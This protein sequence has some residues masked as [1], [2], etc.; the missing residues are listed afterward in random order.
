MSVDLERRRVELIELQK[1]LRATAAG[2]EHELS[3]DDESGELPSWGSDELADHASVTHDREVDDT[4]EENAERDPARDRGCALRGSRTAPT[5]RARCAGRTS[6]AIGSRPSRTP[7]SASRTDAVWS[8]GERAGAGGGLP[9]RTGH[10]RRVDDRTRSSRSRA[11]S[12]RSPPEPGTGSSLLVV[13][14][15]AVVADQLTKH[16]VAS[17]LATR[18]RS[19]AV[20]GPLSIHHVRNS[21]IAFGLF[22]SSTSAVIA[23]D[24]ARGGERCSSSSPGRRSGTRCSRSR[25]GLVLGG[26]LSNLV[27]RVRLG[28]VTDFLDF[29]CWPAF[30]LAD[31]FIVVGVALLFALVRRGR[32]DEPARWRRSAFASLRRRPAS[33]ST[34]S[35]RRRPEIGSRALAERLI[36]ERR[37]AAST[38]ERGEEPPARRRARRS[39]SSSGDAREPLEPEE[40]EIAVVWEDEHLLV[41]DKPA[42]IVV[43][44][45]GG[46]R[47]PAPSSTVCSRSA[48]R[49]ERS[50]RPGIVHRLDRDTSGLLR[51]RAL[52]TRHT[53]ACRS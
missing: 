21:G 33:G 23:P 20:A 38:G 31:T 18:T 36:A 34:A 15:A 48:P 35:S 37:G 2:F 22:A 9:P 13:A 32:P 27:D 4:L 26:S 10:P 53:R 50:E 44:P 1:R 52:R 41:V 46:R 17:A 3:L 39:R 8:A 40:L 16:I 30:N 25:S 12:G 49:V 29:R 42:G 24:H 51:R 45:A 7:R 6:R 28:H 14:G 11:P 43:H 47:G 19:V 5:A